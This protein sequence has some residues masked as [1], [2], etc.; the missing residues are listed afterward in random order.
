M[1]AVHDPLR[2]I[3]TVIV[4]LFCFFLFVQLDERKHFALDREPCP[5]HSFGIHP[6]F[7]NTHLAGPA[8]MYI[9]LTF[10]FLTAHVVRLEEMGIYSA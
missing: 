8:I 10:M 3:I 1:H 2:W 9:A 5:D 7:G 4:S 6:F